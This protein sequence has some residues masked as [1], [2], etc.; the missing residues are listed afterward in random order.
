MADDKNDST[1]LL[2]KQKLDSDKGRLVITITTD[3]Q[4]KEMRME[5]N[6]SV[7]R[8]DFGRIDAIDFANSFLGHIKK[9]QGGT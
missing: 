2:P 5:F 8:I 1:T 3:M 6:Q 4:K 9:L 7:R